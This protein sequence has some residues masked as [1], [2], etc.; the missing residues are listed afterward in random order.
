MHML[1]W[2]RIRSWKKRLLCFDL[3]CFVDGIPKYV[4]ALHWKASF[5]SSTS[6][7]GLFVFKK[8]VFHRYRGVFDEE[9]DALRLDSL[10]SKVD[11]KRPCE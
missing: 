1:T 7:P 10:I 9:H 6:K 4:S 5:F 2:R 8:A 11:F 3:F